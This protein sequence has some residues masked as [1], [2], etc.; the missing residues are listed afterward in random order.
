MFNIWTG[1][2]LNPNN[3]EQ[4]YFGTFY[5][6]CGFRKTI[7]FRCMTPLEPIYKTLDETE[8]ELIKS[9]PRAERLSEI[10]AIQKRPIRELVAEIAEVSKLPV[11]EAIFVA[12]SATFC[13]VF[14]GLLLRRLPLLISFWIPFVL[15]SQL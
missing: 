10:A 4:H 13:R 7:Y 5:L 8:R 6:A 11:L 14:R 1:L 2:L 12:S 9:L 15:F 3:V